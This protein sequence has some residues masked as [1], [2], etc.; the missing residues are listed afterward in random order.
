M[1]VGPLFRLFEFF[2]GARDYARTDHEAVKKNGVDAP[3]HQLYHRVIVTCGVLGGILGFVGGVIGA[4]VS[5]KHHPVDGRTD[6]LYITILS[7]VL[8]AA[9]GMLSGVSWACTAAPGSFLNGP[10]GTKWMGL[11]GTKN[12]TVARFV[13]FV[14]AVLGTAVCVAVVIFRDAKP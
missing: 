6:D 7:P 5:L 9:A 13:A 1:R 10:L 14:I 3:R 8:T 11:I 12:L 2:S 4:F